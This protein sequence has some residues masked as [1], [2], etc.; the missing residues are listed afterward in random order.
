MSRKA[1]LVQSLGS[2]TFRIHGHTIEL[3]ISHACN[4][5]LPWLASGLLRVPSMNPS[6]FFAVNDVRTAIAQ[7]QSFC[8]RKSLRLLERRDLMKGGENREIGSRLQTSFHL[9]PWPNMISRLN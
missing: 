3:T 7:E 1:M 4:S 8:R 6:L 2:I 9:Q 5:A